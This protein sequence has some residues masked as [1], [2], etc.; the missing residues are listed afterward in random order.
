MWDD[1][2]EDAAE[3]DNNDNTEDHVIQ[4]ED[5]WDTDTI[6]GAADKL[7]NWSTIAA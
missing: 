2:A 7:K 4:D 1:T 5:G 6:M 3:L